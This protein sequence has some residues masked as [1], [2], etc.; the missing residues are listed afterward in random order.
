MRTYI[1]D[2]LFVREL[3]WLSNKLIS[4]ELLDLYAFD[5]INYL[6]L[7]IETKTPN[8]LS[9]AENE[10]AKFER[11]L[12]S[13]GTCEYGIIT[14]GH[15]F[16]VYRCYIV[17][18]TTKVEKQYS[19]DLDSLR[20]EIKK[21]GLTDA[22]V[23]LISDVFEN[24]RYSRYLG[25]LKEPFS[26]E[27]GQI[28]PS[29]NDLNSLNLFSQHLKEAVDEL[30][31]LF[32]PFLDTLYQS[33]MKIGGTDK[34]AFTIDEPLS[35]W[36]TY[37]G[38]VPPILM[39]Q[40][41]GKNVRNLIK[42]RQESKLSDAVLRRNA[43]DLKKN[44]GISF[45]E[46]ILNSLISVGIVD[47]RQIDVVVRQKVF[48]LIKAEHI[49]VFSRQTAHVILSRILLHRVSEDRELVPR[50]L[51]GQ[52]MD[53]YIE[54]LQHGK[55][56]AGETNRAFINLIDQIDSLM[57]RVFYSHLYA[58]GIFD[59]W[60]IPQNVQESLDDTNAA[61]LKR[62]QRSINLSLLKVLRILNRFNMKAIERDVW[63]DIYQHYLPPK[64]R[65]RLGGFYTPDEMVTLILDLVGYKSEAKNLC[66]A[67]ILDPAC[68]SGTF[69]VEAAKRL[70]QHL[71]SPA[72]CHSSISNITDD[73]EKSWHILQTTI[74]NI[75]GIDIHPFACFLTEMNFLFLSVD[76]LLKS[77]HIDPQRRIGELNFGCDDSLR[78]PNEKIQLTLTP[79][80]NSN[81]RAQI[82]IRDKAKANKIKDMKFEFVVGN[83]P[84][85][86]VLRGTLSPLFDENTK[87]V[88]KEKYVS[89]TDKYDI[90]VLFLERGIKWLEENGNIGIITQNRYFRRKYGRGIR[91]V[92][93]K[94]CN[95]KSLLDLGHVGK[96]LFPGRSNYPAISIYEL[97]NSKRD[98]F[99]FLETRKPSSHLKVQALAETI[100]Q[101][102]DASLEDEYKSDYM[103]AFWLPQDNL[104]GNPKLPWSLASPKEDLIK[105]AIYATKNCTKMGKICDIIQGATPGGGCLGVYLVSSKVA[106]ELETEC[107]RPAIEAD[108]ITGW[109][110][111]D[112]NKWLI[113]PYDEAG[114]A[115][116]FGNLDL[117]LT[118]EKAITDIEKRIVT[119]EIKYP[120]TAIY[121]VSH[122][123][124][125][126]QRS[127]EKKNLSEFSKK[128]YEYHRPRD[129]KLLSTVPKIVTRRMTK[130]G[131]FSLDN[132]GVLPTDGCIAVA[133]KRKNDFAENLLNLG[134]NQNEAA[135]AT[136]F[137]V[138][139]FL[140]SSL[141]KFLLKT[142]A[143]FWQGSFYQVQEEFLKALPLRKPDKACLQDIRTIVAL[144]KQVVQGEAS[145]I[146]E[147]ERLLFKLYRIE[148]RENEI[149]QYLE[150][151]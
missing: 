75:H 59:W 109:I 70:R 86:G 132:E 29:V 19:L 148:S 6:V 22:S 100:R 92:V 63:K 150:T 143:D 32:A 127:F 56:I 108:D 119:G 102:I 105:K 65:S 74:R 95:A 73:R 151:H 96:T 61:V 28:T 146:I 91:A 27:Y 43:N 107:I 99:L 94:N 130:E 129:G 87:Q 120:K 49:E 110:I 93:K 62:Y 13:V 118:Q 97:S 145:R 60:R 113:Y 139:S 41:I 3:G 53:N 117:S 135:E 137:F 11:R 136:L 7:Y 8:T 17:N 33:R 106:K 58:H 31:N 52:Y 69:A 55:L 2:S 45:T 78:P 104:R 77:K 25:E 23:K 83:P 42:L 4:G 133:L 34:E 68:G 123:A 18:G 64:E 54:E 57:E 20:A 142:T 46:D 26:S 37:S 66:K 51:S 10:T 98:D 44:L 115:M 80:V 1:K 134:M 9:I 47:E 38:K 81:S 112:V 140:N 5:I 126:S 147:I 138:L 67:K 71:E 125:L 35:D 21:E 48:D 30:N 16:I 50:K 149:R 116:N 121:L 101:A 24:F 79:F 89:A 141:V 124:N 14:N 90:Y 76:L 131:Q 84:W 39:F 85:S 122:F 88:Y 128:W 15:K 144:A 111:K 12:Q 40:V 36:S 82:V 103:H 72:A 114:Q